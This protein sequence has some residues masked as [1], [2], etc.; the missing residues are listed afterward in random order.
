VEV[1]VVDVVAA[2]LLVRTVSLEGAIASV[3]PHPTMI[4][5][6]KTTDAHPAAVIM[7]AVETMEVAAIMDEAAVATTAIG[8]NPPRF[9]TR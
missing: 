4:D 2:G 7:M 6:H 3:L 9:Y 1:V 5:L 8:T